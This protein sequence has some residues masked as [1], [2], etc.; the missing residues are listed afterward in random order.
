VKF[1][2]WWI[3]PNFIYLGKTN[4]PQHSFL[5]D[6][7]TV[8][9]SFVHLF[10][11]SKRLLHFILASFI[12]KIVLSGYISVFSDYISFKNFASE[13]PWYI[14]VHLIHG[15]CWIPYTFHQFGKF[16]DIFP[17]NFVSSLFLPIACI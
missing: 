5:K 12:Y 4:I 13:I 1:C 10:L 14:F 3:L 16:L 7:W 17:N 6:I 15:I 2:W 9:G 11:T 8:W